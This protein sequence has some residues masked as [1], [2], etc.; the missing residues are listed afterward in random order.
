M[1]ES[2][3]EKCFYALCSIVRSNEGLDILK[4]NG[5]IREADFESANDLLFY[6]FNRFDM[7]ENFIPSTIGE[8]IEEVYEANYF[9]IYNYLKMELIR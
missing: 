3:K 9:E 2:F 8:D 7:I 6:Y 1:S 5:V 4:E